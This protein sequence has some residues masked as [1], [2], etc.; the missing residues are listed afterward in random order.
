MIPPPDRQTISFVIRLWREPSAEAA[1]WRGQIEHVGSGETAHFQVSTG[2]WEFLLHHV[3]F[4]QS[5][6][7]NESLPAT[8]D[9]P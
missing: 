9:S 5:P 2:L 4:I 6:D 1:P 7:A 8:Q 3:E